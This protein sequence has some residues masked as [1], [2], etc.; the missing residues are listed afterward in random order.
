[1]IIY[2]FIEYPLFLIYQNCPSIFGVG[3]WGGFSHEQICSRLTAQPERY[4]ELN[5]DD[6]IILVNT[7]FQSFFIT[8]QVAIYFLLLYSTVNVFLRFCIRRLSD[9]FIGNEIIEKDQ[10]RY[11]VIRS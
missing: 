4:W 5:I 3:G 9:K 8:V 10:H 2:Y 6:C 7:R 11:L 1:M